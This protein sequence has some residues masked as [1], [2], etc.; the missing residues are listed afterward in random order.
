M[1]PS[2]LRRQAVPVSKLLEKALPKDSLP[3][4][5][6]AKNANLYQVLSRRPNIENRLVHQ[7]RWSAKGIEDCWWQVTRA[8][9]KCEGKHG[10]AWGYKWW[11]G[12]RVSTRPEIIRGGL[13]Y[14]WNDGKSVNLRP[15]AKIPSSTPAAPEATTTA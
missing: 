8:N 9:F 4:A 1:F 5:L 3:A 12:K 6:Q 14:L 11:K 10:K 15:K 13:K 7:T 2:L